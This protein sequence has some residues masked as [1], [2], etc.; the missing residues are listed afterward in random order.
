MKALQR[1]EKENFNPTRL[2]DAEADLILAIKHI[3][4]TTKDPSTLTWM[5]GHSDDTTK[6]DNLTCKQRT[7]VDTDKLAKHSRTNDQVTFQTPHPGSK[8]MLII[9]NK[10]I[11]TAYHE[12]IHEAVVGKTYKKY[13]MGRHPH[14]TNADYNTINF[15]GIGIARKRQSHTHTSRITKYMNGWLNV[16]HQKQKMGRDGQ[17]PCCGAQ[18]E[19]QMHLFHCQNADMK[20]AKTIAIRAMSEHLIS[21]GLPTKIL[22]PFLALVKHFLLNTTSP[23]SIANEFP[24]LKT[25]LLQQERIGPE[26]TLRGYLCKGWLHDIQR[27]TNTQVDRKCKSM[28]IGLWD[29]LFM[30]IWEQRNNI[31]HIPDNIVTTTEHNMLNDELLDWKR[32]KRERF[33]HT[34]YHLTEYDADEICKWTLQHKHNTIKLLQTS[35]KNYI[36]HSTRLSRL[37]PP[38]TTFFNTS[39]PSQNK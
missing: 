30:P 35:H 26:A 19:T 29:Y 3:R 22:Q 7:Q 34:Q 23:Q 13:F 36:T 27:Y 2:L 38:I 31:L 1:I 18:D 24:H 14:I 21:K 10:W 5:R 15:R 12:Q 25:T 33:H 39:Q 6:Y 11:T 16:G 4:S 20:R 37:Q 17:C 8:A 9:D 28:F 32:H